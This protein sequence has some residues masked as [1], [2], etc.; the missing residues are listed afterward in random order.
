MSGSTITELLDKSGN[1]RLFEQN[2]ATALPTL[3]E[4]ALNGK[5]VARFSSQNIRSSNVNFGNPG[6]TLTFFFVVT[7]TDAAMQALFDSA[8]LLENVFRNWSPGNMEWWADDPS[9]ALGLSA[10][11]SYIL[12]FQTSIPSNRNIKYWRNGALVSDNDGGISTAMAW[13]GPALGSNNNGPP[14]VDGA[15][16]NGDIGEVIIYDALLG[17][18]DREMVQEYLGEKW[19]INMANNSSS[20]SST[21][22]SSVLI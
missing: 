6:S 3:A 22:S 9:F 15:W 20:S 19:G 21:S 11:N 12:T 17:D 10:G 8:P 16:Y 7:T 4:G 14:G 5:D 13:N 18:S 2:G 1:G